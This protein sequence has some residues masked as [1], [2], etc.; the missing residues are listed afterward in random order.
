MCVCAGSSR[1]HAPWALKDFGLRCVIAPSFA[2]IFFNNCFKNGMLPIVL[3]PS[4]V[5]ELMKDAEAGLD[6]S[7]DLPQQTITRSNG[8][9][10]QFEV[11]EFRKHCLVNGLDDIGLTLQKDSQ[12][13]TYEAKRAAQFPWLESAGLSGALKGS[14]G[15]SADW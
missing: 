1:E 11:E 13:T 8:Q 7:V 10:V 9:A 14:S 4:V 5:D 15:S 12:I 2:D 3:S 6:L